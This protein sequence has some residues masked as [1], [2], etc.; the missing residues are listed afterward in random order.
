LIPPSHQ[1]QIYKCSLRQNSTGGAPPRFK[2]D[3]NFS[4]CTWA[5]K[6][7][8]TS[9]ANRP[10]LIHVAPDSIIVQEIKAKGAAKLRN[11]STLV[12]MLMI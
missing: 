1:L 9:H 8:V 5:K 11:Y 3:F 2:N 6:K 12:Y 4:A 10:S 7:D